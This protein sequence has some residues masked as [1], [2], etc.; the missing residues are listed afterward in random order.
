MR[1]ARRLIG[2]SEDCAGWAFERTLGSKVR[3]ARAPVLCCD[4]RWTGLALV[5]PPATQHQEIYFQ[6]KR[7]IK[8]NFCIFPDVGGGLRTRHAQSFYC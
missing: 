6:Y 8:K 1:L 5:V 3:V 7:K 2:Y 4:V